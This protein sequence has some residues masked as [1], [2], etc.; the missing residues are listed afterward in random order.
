MPLVPSW[1]YLTSGN[2][3][4]IPDALLKNNAKKRVG[5]IVSIVSEKIYI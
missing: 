4:P 5:Q 2:A 1:F 3:F